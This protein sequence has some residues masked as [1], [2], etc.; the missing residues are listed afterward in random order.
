MTKKVITRHM[1]RGTIDVESNVKDCL[2]Q[3]STS[4]N[5]ELRD[6][7]ITGALSFQV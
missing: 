6:R 2:K 7:I 1:T 4:R 5:L 3:R